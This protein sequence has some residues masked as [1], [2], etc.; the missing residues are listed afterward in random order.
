YATVS[1]GY[2]AG[3]FNTSTA[4]PPDRRLY[5]PEYLWN[6]EAGVNVHSADRS[7]E[8]RGAVFT[9]R[10]SD[11]QVSTS[12]QSDPADPL[13]FVFYTD[14]AARGEN[15]GLEGEF[16]WRPVD[17]LR[18]GANLGLLRARFLDYRVGGE[19][20]S[21]VE[22]PHSPSWT[23]GLNAEWRSARGLF[24]RAE[25]NGVD[26]FAFSASHDQRSSAYHLVNARIGYE[27]DRVSVSVWSRN[28]LDRRYATRGFFFGNE[29]PDFAPKRYVANGDPRQVGATLSVQF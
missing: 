3:G 9:M 10:R 11:Q 17:S 8:F 26:A 27:R 23:Y 15:T 29:P 16:G 5:E 1:R 4:V 18:F 12:S 19:D 24:A 6:V 21:G 13:T 25:L 20:L 14:N 2:K 7:L 28:L 22:P